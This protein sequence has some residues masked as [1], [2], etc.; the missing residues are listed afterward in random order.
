MPFFKGK[1]DKRHNMTET[2]GFSF[3]WCKF[4]LASVQP[5]RYCTTSTQLVP[6]TIVICYSAEHLHKVIKTI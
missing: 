2:E 3:H 4:L 1:H 5:H 6:E